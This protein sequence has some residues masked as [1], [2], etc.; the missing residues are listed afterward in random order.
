LRK[1]GGNRDFVG[2]PE[3]EVGTVNEPISIEITGTPG[4][5]RSEFVGIPEGEV[6]VINSSI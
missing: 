6:G 2:I 3:G 4:P 1:T 5:L